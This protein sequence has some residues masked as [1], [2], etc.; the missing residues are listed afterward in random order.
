MQPGTEPGLIMG[1]VGYMSPSK[2]AASLPPAFR[3]F[4]LRRHP[5]RN[6]FG[7]ACFHGETPA[8]AMTRFL[9]K[10]SRTFRT[11]RNFARP[12]KNC[13]PLSRKKSCAELSLRERHSFRSR[14]AHRNIIKREIRRA[15]SSRPASTR[16]PPKLAGGPGY[17][18]WPQPPR[19]RL[20]ARPRTRRR[21]PSGYEQVTFRTGFLGNARFTPDGS[22]V[23]NVHGRWRQPVYMSAPRERRPRTRA[24]RCDLLSISKSGELAI[25][26]NSSGLGGYAKSGTLARLH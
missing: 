18:P 3:H 20:L 21:A 7:Q 26:L 23:Y 8:D 1:T 6:D 14:S 15:G 10:K 11:A 12:G 5:L 25:L 22:V 4:C 13:P 16:C 19:P 9:K 2:F 17:L 24:E